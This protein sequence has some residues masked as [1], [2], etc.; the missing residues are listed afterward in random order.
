MDAHFQFER[1]LPC[2]ALV[3]ALL[4]KWLHHLARLPSPQLQPQLPI[5]LSSALMVLLAQLSQPLVLLLLPYPALSGV[6]AMVGAH[7]C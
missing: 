1:S 5:V 2:S 4:P 3:A 7:F 6:S